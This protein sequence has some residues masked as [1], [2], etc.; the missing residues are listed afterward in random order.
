LINEM[1]FAVLWPTRQFR[2]MLQL[3][4]CGDRMAPAVTSPGRRIVYSEHH[5]KLRRKSSQIHRPKG[6]K[7]SYIARVNQ[8]L[9]SYS[10]APSFPSSNQVT[11]RCWKLRHRLSRW[12]N[13]STI[14]SPQFWT[15]PWICSLLTI[16]TKS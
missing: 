4:R 10:R 1:V 12:S 5:R 16:V 9:A 2:R 11:R 7:E 6:W 14:L 15:Q 3:L 8:A 13:F